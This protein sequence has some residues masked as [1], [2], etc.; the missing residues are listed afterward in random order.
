MVKF[1]TPT[2]TPTFA[3]KSNRS[4]VHRQ[5]LQARDKFH[6]PP[7]HLLCGRHKCMFLYSDHSSHFFCDRSLLP[8]LL[9]TYCKLKRQVKQDISETYN[10]TKLNLPTAHVNDCSKVILHDLVG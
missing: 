3:K 9:E 10:H 1:L 5:N 2:S 7:T 6:E 4:I 8:I